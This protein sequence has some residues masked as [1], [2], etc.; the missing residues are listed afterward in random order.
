M[1]NRVTGLGGFFFKTADPKKTK[2]WYRKHL[3]IPAGDYGWSFLWQDADGNP[4]RTEWSPMKEDT[5]YFKPSEKQ[6]MMNFRVADLEGLLAV[7]K[8]EGVEII[9]EMETY[10]YGKFGW[11]MDP[12]GNKIELWE[13]REEGF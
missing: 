7:L 10:S 4:G 5:P 2:E 13:P 6:F 9:G 1:K 11:I 3:G 8:E 12:E